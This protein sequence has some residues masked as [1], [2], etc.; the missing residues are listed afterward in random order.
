MLSLVNSGTLLIVGS[1]LYKIGILQA[2]A[3]LGERIKCKKHLEL[4]KAD[5]ICGL[6]V[7]PRLLRSHSQTTSRSKVARKGSFLTPP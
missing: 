6:R 7:L 2:P 3:Y 4:Y 5:Y 1:L